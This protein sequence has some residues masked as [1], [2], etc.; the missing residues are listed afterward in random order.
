MLD[1][2]FREK[3]EF[4]KECLNNVKY[5]TLHKQPTFKIY[6]VDENG[7]VRGPFNS[8]FSAKYSIKHIDVSLD[9]GSLS[10]T[11]FANLNTK[12]KQFNKSMKLQEAYFKKQIKHYE[13]KV[14]N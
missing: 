11:H 8:I 10:K 1:D 6:S 2:N 7:I 5:E 4:Y 9:V 3:L 13:N 14:Y 12:I